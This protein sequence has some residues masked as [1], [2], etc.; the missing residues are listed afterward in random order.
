MQRYRKPK[1]EALVVA[2]GFA[3]CVAAFPAKAQSGSIPTVRTIVIETPSELATRQFFGRIRARETVDL[4]FEVGGTMVRLIPEEGMQVSAGD[5]LAQL[6]LDPFQ[7]AVERAELMLAMAAREAERAET[8]A[9]RQVGATR[10]AEDATTARDLAAIALRDARA[11]L[12]HATLTSPFDGL[13]ALRIRPAF[14]SV[15]AGQPVLRVHDMSEVRVE[16]ALPERVYQQVEDLEAV[17]FS[18]ILPGGSSFPLRLVAFQPETDRIGQSF[19]IALA[20]PPEAGLRAMPGASVTVSVALPRDE[21][22]VNVPATALLARKDRNAQVLALRPD[23]DDLIVSSLEVT[24]LAPSGVGFAVEGLPLGTE[25]VAAGA[26]R[27]SEG[28][29]VRRFTGLTRPEN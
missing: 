22:A 24:V 20:L 12:E 1:Y 4:S 10:Q 21:H 19:R 9:A 28:Q 15:E 23:G 6:D 27:L 18:A 7:R 29:R 11:D 14:S 8:L 16:F 3:L 13:V 25:I 26:H 5:A 2:T 17:A